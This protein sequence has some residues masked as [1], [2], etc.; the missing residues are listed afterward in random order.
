MKILGARNNLAP[1]YAKAW[2]AIGECSRCGEA[3]IAWEWLG[4][5]DPEAAACLTADRPVPRL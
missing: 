4:D 2:Y 5:Y 3:G 1:G